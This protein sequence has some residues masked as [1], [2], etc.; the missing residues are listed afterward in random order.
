MSRTVLVVGAAG[1]VGGA[2][3]KAL[4]KR[5]YSVIGTVL[6]A[7][8][9]AA[10]RAAS[11]TINEIVE[12]DLGN[13]DSALESIKRILNRQPVELAGAV[14]C[15]AIS[16]YGPVEI[17]PLARLRQTL[18][19]NTVADV[20]VFQAAMPSLR[21]SKGKMIFV[22]SFAGKVAMPFIGHYTASKHALEGISDVM[23]QEAR[24]F[25]V[26]VVLIEPGGIKTTMVTNQIATIGRDRAA[27]SPDHSN[28]YGGLFERFERMLHKGASMGLEPMQVA[29]VIVTALEADK[30]KSRYVVGKDSA[31]LI[32]TRR[33]SSDETMDEMFRQIYENPDALPS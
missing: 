17:T 26:P 32:R 12:V 3:V 1:G 23:R 28:L 25:G 9:A 13:A 21:Q 14:V 7:G 19:I 8:E 2:L 29:K 18:E 33:R 24:P 6:N 5:K 31:A 4:L 30:P 20:A 15:A 22:A 27:L 16:P 11:P 10:V